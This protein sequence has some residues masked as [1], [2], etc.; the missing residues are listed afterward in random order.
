VRDELAPFHCSVPPVLPRERIAH[1]SYVRRLLRRGHS[2][3]TAC[4]D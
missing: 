2:R 4:V 3:A 1:L